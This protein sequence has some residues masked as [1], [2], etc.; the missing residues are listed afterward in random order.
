MALQTLN[1]KPDIYA[2]ASFIR[3]QFQKFTKGDSILIYFDGQI[4]YVHRYGHVTYHIAEPG[5][6]KL[7]YYALDSDG[8]ATIPTFSPVHIIDQMV[9]FPDDMFELLMSNRVHDHLVKYGY[10]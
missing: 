3:E 4:R 5:N 1:F 7:S 10:A 2:L 8:N 6:C 9:L